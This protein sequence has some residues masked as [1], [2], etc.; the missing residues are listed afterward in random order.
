[1][2]INN[3]AKNSILEM[4]MLAIFRGDSLQHCHLRFICEITNPVKVL[5]IKISRVNYSS[6]AAETFIADRLWSSLKEI[7]FSIA[8]V[9]I[10]P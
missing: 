6:Y 8:A 9:I 4:G 10:L 7:R 1:M 5:E 2:R 3:S